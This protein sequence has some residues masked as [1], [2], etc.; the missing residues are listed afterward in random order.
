MV[1]SATRHLL[2]CNNRQ[3]KQ[4]LIVSERKSGDTTKMVVGTTIDQVTIDI[5]K[6]AII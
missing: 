5:D 2:R 1:G 6:G 4:R 3:A